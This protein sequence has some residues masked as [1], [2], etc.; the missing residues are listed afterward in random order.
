MDDIVEDTFRKL[1]LNSPAGGWFPMLQR[2]YWFITESNIP[3]ADLFF[4]P[5]LKEIVISPLSSWID[6]Q[7][8][9]EIVPAIASM[10][11][12]LPASALQSVRVTY[13]VPWADLED[14]LSSV[15]LRCGS[16][17]TEFI[18][19]IPLSSAAINHLI[20]L[21]NLRIWR[22]SG[23]PPNYSNLPL[24]P[25][26]APL[27]ELGLGGGTARGWLSLFK[28]L[29]RSLPSTQGVT[30]LARVKE[31]LE[32]LEFG[33]SPDPTIDV[34]FTSTVRIFRNL[35]FL[36]VQTNCHN[37]DYKGRC[38]FKLDDDNVAKFTMALPQLE[39]LLLGRPCSKN[40]CPTTVACLLP[41]SVH[42]LKLQDLEI[43]F[44]TTNIVDDLKNVSEDPR[45]EEMR[46]LPRSSLPCL[47][48]WHT[49]LT[50]D[51]SDF[52][53]VVKGMVDIFPEL[54]RCEEDAEN[55]DWEE[56][57][58]EVRWM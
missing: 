14:S 6:F 53:A 20:H 28:R 42:C 52:D 46:S 39:R 41:I 29:E 13:G 31:S 16:S 21:P 19:P 58:E 15:A 12:A 27:T 8:P 11:S 45:F 1:R 44:N 9:H 3:Y 30:P 56:F 10:I 2:F 33:G 24:P 48:V 54:E 36:Y 23:S 22:L 18:S 25:A 17:L 34:F 5:Y 43:H 50:V 49:P 7:V 51:E 26:F 35:V 4:S 47:S 40:T 55:S 37:E 38:A 32:T 57:F